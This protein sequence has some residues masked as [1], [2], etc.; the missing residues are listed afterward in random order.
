MRRGS[1]RTSYAASLPTSTA[2]MSVIIAGVVLQ[3]QVGL[4]DVLR[5]FVLSPRP[6]LDPRRLP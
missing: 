3:V 5:W 6:L 4:L 2:A 1:V